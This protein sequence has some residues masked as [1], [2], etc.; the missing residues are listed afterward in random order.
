MKIGFF[1]NDEMIEGEITGA[2]DWRFTTN[3]EYIRKYF[4]SGILYWSMFFLNKDDIK[5]SIY[6]KIAVWGDLLLDIRYAIDND[7]YKELVALTEI[8]NEKSS[9]QNTHYVIMPTN[10]IRNIEFKK[11]YNGNTSFFIPQSKEE[12]ALIE[13]QTIH[14]NLSIPTY[15]YKELI[16]KVK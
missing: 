14:T 15:N 11:A 6:Q 2:R 10:D 13:V 4:P 3:N 16:T 5:F 12:Y 7:D 9:L 1:L 8:L